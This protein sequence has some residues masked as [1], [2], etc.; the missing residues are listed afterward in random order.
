METFLDGKKADL[1]AW[2]PD[3]IGSMLRF[4]GAASET[5]AMQELAVRLATSELIA[6]T[7]EEL[8]LTPE[9][10]TDLIRKTV[11]QMAAK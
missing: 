8:P 10:R 5:A 1:L 3:Q 7:P 6:K 4:L 11:G 9:G 2:P